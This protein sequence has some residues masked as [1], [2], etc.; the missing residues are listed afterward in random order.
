MPYNKN[1]LLTLIVGYGLFT[2][3]VLAEDFV[4]NVPEGST[5]SLISLL[6]EKENQI[7]K[8]E[9]EKWQGKLSIDDEKLIEA[10]VSVRLYD[11]INAEIFVRSLEEKEVLDLSEIIKDADITRA[12]QAVAATVD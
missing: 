9:L 1:V 6:K 2:T 10:L 3:P 12:R 11:S 8:G 7:S 4:K 5:S